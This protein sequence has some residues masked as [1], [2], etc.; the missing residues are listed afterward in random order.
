MS[1]DTAVTS[2]SH[3][4]IIIVCA[5]SYTKKDELYDKWIKY[6]QPFD[7]YTYKNV[8][9]AVL[10]HDMTLY[11]KL[12]CDFS[13][14]KC[15]FLVKRSDGNIH[16]I[17]I[18]TIDE[19]TVPTLLGYPRT[20]L[21][22]L[23]SIKIPSV[24]SNLSQLEYIRKLQDV[25]YMYKVTPVL[26]GKM[27]NTLKEYLYAV[28][29]M[30]QSDIDGKP[31]NDTNEFV[32]WRGDLI[33]VGGNIWKCINDYQ[34]ESVVDS[35]KRVTLSKEQIDNGTVVTHEPEPISTNSDVDSNVKST[36]QKKRGGGYLG[37]LKF[38]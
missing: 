31:F 22:E 27:Y 15:N 19:K 30:E 20:D 14:S 1:S 36:T 8:E 33:R 34:P 11:P 17:N 32:I 7:K 24:W 5:L 23:L 6:I 26:N 35:L 3:T 2:N 29:D 25:E 16:S 37:Y 13:K 21:T 4:K 10:M 12:R 9:V 38:W 28:A 18:E